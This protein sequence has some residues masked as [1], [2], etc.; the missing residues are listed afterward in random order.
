MIGFPLQLPLDTTA[1]R[2]MEL[3]AWSGPIAGR[4]CPIALVIEITSD[5]EARAIAAWL[6]NTP[7]AVPIAAA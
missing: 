3:T 6:A 5:A 1:P 4:E 7:V 2:A